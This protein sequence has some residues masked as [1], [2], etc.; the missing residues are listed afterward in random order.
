MLSTM[1]AKRLPSYRAFGQVLGKGSRSGKRAS[2][3]IR[4]KRLDQTQRTWER[5]WLMSRPALSL[6][7]PIYIF[8]LLSLHFFFLFFFNLKACLRVFFYNDDMIPHR[9]KVITVLMNQKVHISLYYSII[10][11]SFNLI[12]KS[13]FLQI[14][15]FII[16]TIY[17]FYIYKSVE[18]LK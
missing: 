15:I 16:F 18:Y 9:H 3:G 13:N 12:F 7:P 4:G 10:K 11:I 17:I 2:C 5:Q 8:F 1:S 14:K 6:L